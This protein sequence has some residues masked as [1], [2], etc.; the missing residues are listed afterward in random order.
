[1]K[2]F[3]R[4]AAVAGLCLFALSLTAEAACKKVYYTG[5]DRDPVWWAGRDNARTNWSDKVR[6]HLGASWSRWSKATKASD[7][8][9]WLP[10]QGV[11]YCVARAKPCK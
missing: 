10:T 2:S 3:A 1:M 7:S 4:V 5:S 11:N 8:C 6:G 9:D